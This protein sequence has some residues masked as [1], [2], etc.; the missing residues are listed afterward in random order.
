[1]R[2]MLMAA[3]VAA[4]TAPVAHAAEINVFTP[5]LVRESGLPKVVEA[6]EKKTGTKVNLSTHSMGS[7]IRDIRAGPVAPDVIFLL[8]NEM[9]TLAIARDVTP[10]IPVGR[11]YMGMAV[12]KSRP[13][14]DI[15]TMEKFTAVLKASKGVASSDPGGNRGSVQ[16][17]MVADIVKDVGAVSTHPE[18][19][20]GGPTTPNG[21]AWLIA[22]HGDLTLQPLVQLDTVPEVTIVGKLPPE[23]NA[24]LDSSVAVSKRA[25]N[26][27][28][29]E[30]FIKF[31]LSEEAR[32]L[33]KKN[34]ELFW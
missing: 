27:K 5:P 21:P 1:M 29:A 8:N 11:V 9:G 17:N 19:L 28:D 30:A 32:P 7:A 2:M 22:G 14:P 15:S 33:W 20:P 25:A 6:F 31:A 18:T 4:L 16:A 23:L 24:F 13:A 34:Y 10:P 26:R 12:L 3:V